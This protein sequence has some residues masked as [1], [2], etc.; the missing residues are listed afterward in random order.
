[1]ARVPSCLGRWS[2][3]WQRGGGPPEA[4]PAASLGLRPW[5]PAG[6]PVADS[7]WILIFVLAGLDPLPG[8]FSRWA[9]LSRD[10][11]PG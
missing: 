11:F 6:G 7:G 1:M 10:C 4:A 9:R 5:P 8:L 2:A 3:A